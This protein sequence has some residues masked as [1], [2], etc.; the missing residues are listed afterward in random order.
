MA[1]IMSII[2]LDSFSSD[3]IREFYNQLMDPNHTNLNGGVRSLIHGKVVE[4]T[5]HDLR[6]EFDLIAH[7]N[8]LDVV[9]KYRKDRDWTLL[10]MVLHGNSMKTLN[11]STDTLTPDARLVQ[12]I[13]RNTVLLKSGDTRTITAQLSY[14]TYMIWSENP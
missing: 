9:E 10:N 1:R 12:E 3:L 13:L 4:I 14:V 2:L 7:E 11:H 5:H 6:E 8:M